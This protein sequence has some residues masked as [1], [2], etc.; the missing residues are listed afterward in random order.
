MVVLQV[1]NLCTNDHVRYEYKQPVTVGMKANLHAYWFYSLLTT[2][3]PLVLSG[4]GMLSHRLLSS[5][6]AAYFMPSYT[7]RIYQSSVDHNPA[8]CSLILC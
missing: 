5:S 8:S 3:Y 4:E 6:V 7:H 1:F 2:H